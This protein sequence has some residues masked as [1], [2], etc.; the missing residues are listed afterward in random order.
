MVTLCD[1]Y[2]LLVHAGL[3]QSSSYKPSLFV[4]LSGFGIGAE[5]DS[6]S[7]AAFPE[8]WKMKAKATGRARQSLGFLRN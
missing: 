2:L 8:T 6:Q 5:H 7:A 3:G 4:K 1:T